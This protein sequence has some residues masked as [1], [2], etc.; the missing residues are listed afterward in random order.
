MKKILTILT[1]LSFL[2][3]LFNR[4]LI[5]CFDF[6]IKGFLIERIVFLV[7]ILSS[8]IL[9]RYSKNK[10]IIY[11]AIAFILISNFMRAFI[12][13]LI[14]TNSEIKI[15][16]NLYLI[17]STAIESN[18]VYHIMQ[19]NN[20]LEQNLTLWNAVLHYDEEFQ[21]L[22]NFKKIR[23]IKKDNN[24]LVLKYETNNKMMIDTFQL[25]NKK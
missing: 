17:E 18:R 19:R 25:R 16:N 6:S 21:D 3:L 22:K 8:V 15:T 13:G 4:I 2:I 9:S 11:L 23:L 10:R 20:W 14:C 1:V 7:F 5:Y 24:I 12:T